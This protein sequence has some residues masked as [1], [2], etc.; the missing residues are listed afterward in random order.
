MATGGDGGRLVDDPADRVRRELVAAFGAGVRVI[1]VLTDGAAMPTEARLPPDVAPLARCQCRRLRH[2]DATADLARLA[3]DLAGADPELGEALRRGPYSE[4][5]VDCPYPGMVPFGAEQARFFRGRARRS[6]T[7][8]AGVSR[9]WSGL[10]IC[11]TG[12]TNK[13]AKNDSLHLKW[14]G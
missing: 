11:P 10:N 2:R 13:S 6:A 14:P 1:P 9:K 8:P 7:P 3:A 12:H 4:E 5:E